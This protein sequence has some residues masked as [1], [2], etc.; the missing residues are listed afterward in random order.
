MLSGQVENVLVDQVKSVNIQGINLIQEKQTIED[1][2]HDE[3]NIIDFEA[4]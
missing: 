3:T 2:E 4:Q 1:N